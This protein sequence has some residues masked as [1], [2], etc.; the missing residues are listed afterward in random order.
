MERPKPEYQQH[1]VFESMS[2]DY[3][4]NVT[5]WLAIEFKHPTHC[6]NS[7]RAVNYLVMQTKQPESKQIEFINTYLLPK[8]KVEYTKALGLE[9]N[10]DDHVDYAMEIFLS[11]DYLDTE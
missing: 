9:P 11:Q 8:F 3:Q 6:E 5:A 4:N 2:T 10:D 1:E 7:F